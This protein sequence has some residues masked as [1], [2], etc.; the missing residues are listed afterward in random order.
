[1]TASLA[2]AA[3]FL[4]VLAALWSNR[5]PSLEAVTAR[6]SALA[7]LTAEDL[8]SSTA[9]R[10]IDEGLDHSASAALVVPNAQRATKP[11]STSPR[12]RRKSPRPSRAA[13]P[14][15]S[16]HAPAAS[17][18][19]PSASV[20][21]PAASVAKPS[22]GRA[23]L[24]AVAIGGACS[25]MIDGVSRG[26]TAHARVDVAPGAHAVTCRAARGGG[27]RT[28]NITLAAGEVKSAVFKL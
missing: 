26:T 15:A 8:A 21:A 5:P 13:E 16:V 18:A 3:L 9:K 11:A 19:K 12:A 17:V 1:M 4:I 6:A 25:F 7:T 23:T 22:G 24:F 20:H 28:R 27:S 14:A 2:T 10:D